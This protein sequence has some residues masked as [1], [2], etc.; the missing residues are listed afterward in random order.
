MSVKLKKEVV[1]GRE[2]TLYADAFDNLNEILLNSV[3]KFPDKEAIVFEDERITYE[4]FYNRVKKVAAFLQKRFGVNKG[5]RV[6]ILSYNTVQFCETIF[7]ASLIGGIF[8]P[9]NNRLKPSELQFILKDAQLKVLVVED[10]LIK[11]AE[12]SISLAN[13]DVEIV[14]IGNSDKYPLFNKIYE[15]EEEPTIPKIK[16]EDPLYIMYTSGTTGLPKGALGTHLGISQN[17]YNF[18]LNLGT[19]HTDRTLITVPLFHVTGI[20]ASLVHMIFVGG[21]S[22]IMHKFKTSKFLELMDKEKITYIN[23]VPTIFIFLINHENRDQYDLGSLKTAVTG[24]APIAVNTVERLLEIFPNLR[25]INNY[26]ATECTGSCT[27]SRAE[28]AVQKAAS[29]G[30]FSAIIDWKIVDDEGNELP[31]GE[32]GEL[33]I[34]G[35]TVIPEYWKNEKATQSEFVNGYWKSGD[36]GY[37]DEDGFFFLMDRKKDMITRGGENIYSAEIE[38]V[39]YNHPSVLEATVVGVPDEIFGEEVLALIVLKEG[40]HADENDIRTFAAEHL[41]DYKVPKYI[42]FVKEIP[43]NPSGKILKHKIREQFVERVKVKED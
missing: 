18:Q 13:V 39:L 4:A 19:D 29:V 36:V 42:E 16:R 6:G 23:T 32:P 41:A 3:Q 2:L 10:E 38:N 22:V 8:V 40:L 34:K 27:F 15:I 7:A 25:F 17:S 24:G 30:K 26:G 35:P 37:I 5:D 12:E 28:T 21:T 33:W 1:F 43:R 20:V 9:L 31:V 11:L 14:V